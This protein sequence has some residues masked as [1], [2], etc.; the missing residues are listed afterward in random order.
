MRLASPPLPPAPSPSEPSSGASVPLAVGG[1]RDERQRPSYVRAVLRLRNQRR[2]AST[3]DRARNTR[4]QHEEAG[5]NGEATWPSLKR[6]ENLS[7]FQRKG[8]YVGFGVPQKGESAYRKGPRTVQPSAQM[9]AVNAKRV[10]TTP[11]TSPKAS[12][13]DPR[14]DEAVLK[15]RQ[16]EI[17]DAVPLVLRQAVARYHGRE[18]QRSFSPEAWPEAAAPGASP[19]SHQTSPKDPSDFDPQPSPAHICGER[20][21]KLVPSRKHGTEVEA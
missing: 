3:D 12:R 9:R 17:T 10:V 1:R 14:E 11:T 19:T 15:S 8:G 6:F 7:G 16:R 5:R 18:R 4:I 13:P 21:S 2:A 20:S